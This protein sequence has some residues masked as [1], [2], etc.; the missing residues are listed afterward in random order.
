V[1]EAATAY[2][3]ARE[4]VDLT[5]RQLAAAQETFR[6]QD[7]RYRGGANTILDLLEAQGQLTLAQATVVQALYA[8]NLSRAGLEAVVGRQLFLGRDGS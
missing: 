6:V 3:I 7:L 1:V 5:Q 2:R 4:A 8:L